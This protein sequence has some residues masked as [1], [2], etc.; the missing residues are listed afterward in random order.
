[1]P[2]NQHRLPFADYLSKLGE[3]KDF[4]DLAIKLTYFGLTVNQAKLYLYLLSKHESVPARVISTELG[5]HR[6]DAYRTLRELV[7][8]GIA[9][10]HLTSPKRYTAVA[11]HEALSSLIERSESKV[12]FLKNL[13]RD[14][15]QSL[16]S[17]RALN[18]ASRTQDVS[19]DSFNDG[20]YKVVSG[21]EGYYAEIKTIVRN[22]RFEVLRILSALGLKLTYKLGLD[23]DYAT[24]LRR[25]ASIRI[26]ADVNK[27]NIKQA[28][29]LSK[30]VEL[31]HLDGINA[32]FTVVDR[33]TTIFGHKFD[34][35]TTGSSSAA[36][37]SAKR[38]EE[39]YLVLSD[40][41]FAEVSYF[42]FD[43]LWKIAGQLN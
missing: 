33:K 5:I 6:V 32:R 27:D 20:S 23:R 4:G 24:A 38:N 43:H 19:S 17:F 13:Q 1:M 8:L 36:S 18:N 3:R 22:S 31:R 21:R 7:N 11:S 30:L 26:I 42:F 25:G 12:S 9:E 29:R 37:S 34:D 40:P 39:N 41:R 10:L 35:S 15:D 2:R 16:K 28:R 14:L